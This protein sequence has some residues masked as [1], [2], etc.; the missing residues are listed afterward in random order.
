MTLIARLG[1]GFSFM[2]AGREMVT[3]KLDRGDG[4]GRTP[5]RMVGWGA[6]AGLMAL[7]LVAKWPW[8]GSDFV[9]A[10]VLIG[11]V[12]LAFELVVRASGNMAYRA[13]AAVALAACFLLV[14]INA[15]VSIIGDGDRANLMYAGVIGVGAIGAMVARARA[16]GMARAMALTAA[17]QA[18]VAAIALS[19]GLGASEPP[20]AIGILILNSFFVA[21]F[22]ASAWL[23]RFAA[24]QR[25]GAEITA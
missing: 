5:W 6:A 23:F 17:A 13:G 4:R 16:A 18:V 20:G 12:G 9:F 14:W 22:A 21:L 25:Q 24:R 19:G 3:T 10:G 11:G 7:P 1:E 2:M 15:A 8:T